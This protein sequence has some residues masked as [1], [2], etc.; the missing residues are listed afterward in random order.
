MARSR[1]QNEDFAIYAMAISAV[2]VG[3][4]LLAQTRRIADPITRKLP[5]VN[6]WK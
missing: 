4:D 3:R 1:W 6:N 5:Y 2:K